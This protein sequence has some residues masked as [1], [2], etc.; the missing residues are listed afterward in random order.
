MLT[1][2]FFIFASVL[3]ML[4]ALILF[5][6]RADAIQKRA[7]GPYHDFVGPLV[8]VV[9]MILA[10]LLNVTVVLLQRTG[11]SDSHGSLPSS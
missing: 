5:R 9:I 6:W 11:W 10:V 2:M 1:G 3:G 4:Y 7:D 8:I